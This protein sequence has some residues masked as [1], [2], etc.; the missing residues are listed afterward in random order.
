MLLCKVM[1]DQPNDVPAVMQGKL[2]LKYSNREIDA[3]KAVAKAYA[4]R[5]LHA[6]EQVVTQEYPNE[7]QNDFVVQTKLKELS[8]KLLEQ[9]LQRLLEPYER[10]EIGHIAKLIDLP[11]DSVQTKLG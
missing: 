11:I 1:N 8:D 7:I 5:S 6:F 4:D 10:V 3:M 9:N 2:T